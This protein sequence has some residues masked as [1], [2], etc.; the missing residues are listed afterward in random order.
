MTDTDCR[1]L[2]NIRVKP[3][4]SRNCIE[5]F[6]GDVLVVALTAPPVDGEAN[7]QLIALVAKALKVGRSTV[8]IVRGETSRDKLIRIE[9]LSAAQV[10]SALA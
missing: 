3:R 9:G 2:V 10:R 8:S 5:G 7:Q 6:S 4:T 1:A